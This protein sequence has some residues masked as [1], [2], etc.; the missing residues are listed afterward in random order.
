MEFLRL[1]VKRARSGRNTRLPPGDP[2]RFFRLVHYS[3]TSDL[4]AI[5]DAFKGAESIAVRTLCSEGKLIAVDVA[6][7]LHLVQIAAELVTVGLQRDAGIDGI[8][9]RLAGEFPFPR[10]IGDHR[11]GGQQ[12]R[13]EY[14]GHF[15]NRR[16]CGE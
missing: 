7:E 8:A 9:E 13:R 2:F 10:N 16:S 11:R 14:P 5:D 3:R 4:I 12:K 15:L 6:F 1:E